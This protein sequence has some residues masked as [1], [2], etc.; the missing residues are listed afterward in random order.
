M[1]QRLDELAARVAERCPKDVVPVLLRA[2]E[3]DATA[4]AADVE[5][6]GH[7]VG[8]DSADRKMN[9]TVSPDKQAD[10]RAREERPKG[11]QDGLHALQQPKELVVASRRSLRVLR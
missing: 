6:P 2:G 7:A 8:R 10:Q 1:R 4:H 5:E 3:R 9:C 11:E